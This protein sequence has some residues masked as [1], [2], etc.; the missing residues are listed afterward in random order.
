MEKI[1]ILLVEDNPG[2]IF[3]IEEMLAEV[4]RFDYTLTIATS[5]AETTEY[6]KY[7]IF[8]LIILDLG[9]PDSYG[10]N[11]FKKIYEENND[12]PILVITGLEDDETGKNAM[13]LG[14]K[15]YLIKGRFDNELLSRTILYAIE[16]QNYLNRI[17]ENEELIFSFINAATDQFALLSEDFQILI[18]NEAM[19]R[20]WETDDTKILSNKI[21]KIPCGTENTEIINCFKEV[22]KTGEPQIFSEVRLDRK[23]KSKTLHLKVF[24][25]MKGLGIVMTDISEIKVAEKELN[26]KN[27][28]LQE[29]NTSK[30]RLFSIIAHDLKSPFQ[31]FLQLTELMADENETLSV[32]ELRE[33]SKSINNT[34]R[35][36]YILLGNL[37]EWA[38]LNKGLLTVTPSEFNIY[39]VVAENFILVRESAI[40]KEILIENKVPTD[41]KVYADRKMIDTVIRNLL[42]NAIKFTERGGRISVTSLKNDDGSTEIA[43]RDSGIGISQEKIGKLFSL[44]ENKG[45]KGT[46]GELSTGLGLV[47]CR[48]LIEKNKGKIRIESEEGKGSI[49][50]ISIPGRQTLSR[51]VSDCREG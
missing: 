45:R 33:F 17:R 2:D 9:L 32:K 40:Q 38:S 10:I 16:S 30:D 1:N 50:F 23:E 22:L 36:L 11:S 39:D 43:V 4:N 15:N 26:E 21:S 12:I 20:F 19:S 7:K 6:L 44:G 14:A 27:I 3:I 37:L 34:A 31:G 41:E 25:V 18:A 47:L 28:L 29:A 51:Q 24:K 8:N 42:S 48:E 46:E 13:R 49:F 5:L 35:N